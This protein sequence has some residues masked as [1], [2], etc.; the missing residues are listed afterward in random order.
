MGVGDVP[1]PQDKGEAGSQ[2]DPQKGNFR[3]VKMR[4]L[5]SKCADSFTKFAQG[6]VEPVPDQDYWMR[7]RVT[8]AGVVISRQPIA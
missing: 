7:R 1:A 8:L 5:D 4:L 2:R 6:V 3:A